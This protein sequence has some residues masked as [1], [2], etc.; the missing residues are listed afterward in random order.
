LSWWSELPSI[1][2]EPLVEVPTVKI[3][4]V[5]PEVKNSELAYSDPANQPGYS[6]PDPR[7]STAAENQP[8]HDVQFSVDSDKLPKLPD[9]VCREVKERLGDV[10]LISHESSS[11]V[12]TLSIMEAL[13]ERPH[14]VI[15]YFG[16]GSRDTVV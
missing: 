15:G 4:H 5:N 8:P 2:D 12:V 6:A 16:F 1:P 3:V 14:V 7:R 10:T 9:R 13:P 11:G